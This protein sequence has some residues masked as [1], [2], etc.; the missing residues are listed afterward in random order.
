VRLDLDQRLVT[1]KLSDFNTFQ[2]DR[3]M[4]FFKSEG[5][6][7]DRCAVQISRTVD[8]ENGY[9]MASRHRDALTMHL[10]GPDRHDLDR[11]ARDLSVSRAKTAS[12]THWFHRDAAA[13]NARPETDR[14]APQA[15]APLRDAASSPRSEFDDL[16]EIDVEE[17]D[18]IMAAADAAAKKAAA[19]DVAPVRPLKRRLPDDADDRAVVKRRRIG[20]APARQDEAHPA[21][22]RWLPGHGAAP[23]RGL[24]RLG[25]WA[26][27]AVSGAR[28]DAAMHAP[29][30]EAPAPRRTRDEARPEAAA[31]RGGHTR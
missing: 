15:D 11:L 26:K 20:N 19:R 23:A 14:G 30:A 21:E 8:A 22:P 9:V 5:R 31:R 17:F 25:A 18:R 2:H 12:V 3:A 27:G 10:V 28:R 4:T 24:R 13:S 1:F 7:F 16:S 6:T 29:A